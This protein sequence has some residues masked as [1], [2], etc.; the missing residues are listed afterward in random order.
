MQLSTTNALDDDDDGDGRCYS[1][2]PATSR[3]TMKDE[4]I[5]QHKDTN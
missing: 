2:K 5:F 1:F 3:F 4:T